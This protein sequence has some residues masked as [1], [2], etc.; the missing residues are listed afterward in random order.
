MQIGNDL[1]GLAEN[2]IIF[3]PFLINKEIFTNTPVQNILLWLMFPKI[4]NSKL[5][6]NTNAGVGVGV[7]QEG[8]VPSSI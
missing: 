7:E 3:F 4:I 1:R 5:A 6:D 8:G 2:I